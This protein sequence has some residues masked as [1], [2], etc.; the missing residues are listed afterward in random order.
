[1]HALEPGTFGKL[2]GVSLAVTA[3]MVVTRI[4]LVFPGA[5]LHH[6]LERQTGSDKSPYP[7][8]RHLLFT[9]WAGIRGG[10]SLIV[11]LALPLAVSGGS[12]LPGARIANT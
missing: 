3:A 12:A 1:V 11:A 7:S 8:W 4:V 6:W 2:I 5:Y 10:D 9:G